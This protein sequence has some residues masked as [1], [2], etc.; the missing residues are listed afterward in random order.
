MK[1]EIRDVIGIDIVADTVHS[2]I[3]PFRDSSLVLGTSRT[4]GLSERPND[5]HGIRHSIDLYL[6]APSTS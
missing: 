2:G 3:C 1:Y 5:M 4:V 6:L